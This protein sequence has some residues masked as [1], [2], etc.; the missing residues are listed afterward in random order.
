[1][2]IPHVIGFACAV[3]L[4][5][6]FP[7]LPLYV[8]DVGYPKALVGAMN[9]VHNVTQLLAR[10]VGGALTDSVGARRLAPFGTL[11]Y[12]LAN[13]LVLPP[14]PA[15]LLASRAALGLGMGALWPPLL[16]TVADTGRSLGVFNAI[17]QLPM[18]LA[19]PI[20]GYLY[21]QVGGWAFGILA[22]PALAVLPLTRLLP[23]GGEGERPPLREVIKRATSVDRRVLLA[24][25]PAF[26][27]AAV[28]PTIES[29]VPLLL[30]KL[31]AGAGLIGAVL[32]AR[33]A[34]AV[35]LQAPCGWLADRVSP[36]LLAAL[37]C[38]LAGL[39]VL[40][41][42][43]VNNVPTAAAILC[44]GGLGYSL[45]QPASLKLVAEISGEERGLGMGWW[46]SIMSLGR[47]IGS[48]PGLLADVSL[49]AVFYASGAITL[50]CTPAVLRGARPR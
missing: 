31:G 3:S 49:S 8:V 29:F 23:G 2:V 4:A 7:I 27:T 39:A 24:S 45:A 34:V 43:L 48:A 40:V 22:L 20:G 35:T 15:T 11:G 37:G 14:H 47:L 9:L 25:L 36:R 41:L 44:L 26:G 42:P 50:L 38:G 21:R 1:M 18:I 46:G 17:T 28:Q 13:L 16:S 6:T 33:N 12:A 5:S 10:P 30:K 19:P 32:A